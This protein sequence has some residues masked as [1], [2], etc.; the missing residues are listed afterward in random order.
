[1]SIKIEKTKN[2]NELKLE[3]TIEAEKFDEAIKSVYHKNMKHFNVPGFRKGKV[4]MHIVEKFYGDEIFYEDAFNEVVAPVY[5]KEL[6][7]NKIEAVSKPDIDITQIGKGKDLIFTAI[8]QTKP[9]VTVGKYKGIEIPKIEYNVSEE[10]INHELSHMQEKNSRLVTVEDRA[11]EDKDIAVI[12]F[13]GFV[14]G[15]AFEGGKAENHELTIGSHTFIE[16]FEDQVIGM[17]IDEEKEINVKFPDEYFSKELAGKDATFKVKLHQI[18][19]K[20]L[21]NLDDEFAKDASE[22]DTLKELK[23]SIQKKLEEENASKAKYETEEA[24]IKAVCE[25]TEIEIPSGMIETEIDNMAKE[26]E[27]RLAYQG[28]KLDDYLKMLGKTMEDFRKEYEEQAKENVKS[29]LVLEAVAKD[30]KVEV[31]EEEIAEKIKE[32]AEKYNRKEDEIKQNE[33]LKKYIEENIKTDKT[34]KLIV[35]NAKVAKK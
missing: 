21:P 12:D 4:P 24:A 34:I 10:D 17:K 25:D 26:I 1:M 8:V 14:D 30:A 15:V 33:Q 27:G 28:L 11:V 13:E 31:S 35:D 18:K 22:F 19:K 9:E 16:G 20:E 3:F 32:M 6:T 29:K 5:E 23:E 7:E 2:N